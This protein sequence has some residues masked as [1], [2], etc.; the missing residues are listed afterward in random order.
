MARTSAAG[1]K[2]WA[3]LAVVDTVAELRRTVSAWRA[4][5]AT[6]GLVPTMG[7]LHR[8]HMALVEFAQA[9]TDLVV[10]SIFVNPTQFGENEDY[11]TYPRD[12]EGDLAKLVAAGVDLA[13]T[14]RLGEIY[15]H[16][17]STTVSV[18]GVSD[19]L[20]GKARPGHFDGVATV[21]SKLLLHCL[22]DL[23][24]FG[25]KDYQQLQVIRRMARDLDIPVA[26]E[27][28][29][30]VRE[31]D[32]LALSSRNAY[33]CERERAAAPALYRVLCATARAVVE[34]TPAA[35]ARERA[36]A[37]LA[38]AGFDRVE[39]VELCDAETLAPVER[40]ARPAR[41]LAA[42]WLGRTRVIDN[43]AVPLATGDQR[44]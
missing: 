39:Y 1:E 3:G 17:F 29:P 19:G 20:C 28:V 38:A 13:F 23:A 32:G 33:L 18:S 41:L 42:A 6:V 43:V 8:A 31:D 40:P 5:G 9:R 30:T 27:G 16:G 25:E 35:A 4:V 7:Y 34:G 44:T 10:T 36:H 26:I 22:P 15:P 21:V 24:V 37:A 11:G 12:L 14:P 2:V